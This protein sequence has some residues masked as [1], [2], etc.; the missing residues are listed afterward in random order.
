MQ[1]SSAPRSRREG[2]HS[3]GHDAESEPTTPMRAAAIA[4]VLSGLDTRLSFGRMGIVFSTEELLKAQ[5]NDS[6]CLGLSD[7]LRETERRDAAGS[8]ADAEGGWN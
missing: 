8:A 6:F 4:A 1:V 3:E 2:E 5:Q 7:G